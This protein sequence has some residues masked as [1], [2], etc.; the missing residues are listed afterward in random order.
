MRFYAYEDQYR[1][2][3]QILPRARDGDILVIQR[4]NVSGLSL[5]SDQTPAADKA[6]PRQQWTKDKQQFV[7]YK[8]KGEYF[9]LAPDELLKGSPISVYEAPSI[10]AAQIT[11]AELNYARDLARWSRRYGLEQQ[12][13]SDAPIPNIANPPVPGVAPASDIKL[14]SAA[15]AKKR[16]GRPTLLIEEIVP[17]MFCDL[18]A[19][20]SAPSGCGP[21][22][23]GQGTDRLVT[24]SGREMVQPSRDPPGRPERLLQLVRDRLHHQL[25]ADRVPRRIQER[26]PGPARPSGLDFWR[27][28]RSPHE[29]ERC[30]PQ[31]PNRLP[32]QHPTEAE[33]ERVAGGHDGRGL[34]V[35]GQARRSSCR[36]GRRV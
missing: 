32:A 23:C 20:V 9:I 5:A 25:A 19:E 11:D 31:R 3:P 21:A 15:L 4:V 28:V 13:Q 16:S 30:G 10:R 29:A 22:F 6:I 34:Q 2:N 7:A 18:Y 24:L 1:R 14:V 8:E 12:I 35:S 36:Q 17:D 33:L 27:A 26:R